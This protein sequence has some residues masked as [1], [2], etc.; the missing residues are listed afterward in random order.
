MPSISR[1]YPAAVFCPSHRAGADDTLLVQVPAVAAALCLPFFVNFSSQEVGRAAGRSGHLSHQLS[2][3]TPELTCSLLHVSVCLCLVSSPSSLIV[4]TSHSRKT[5]TT[6]DSSSVT[7]FISSTC[8]EPHRRHLYTL[9][10]PLPLVPY[11]YQ[12]IFH[13]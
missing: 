6:I 3:H 8:T 13:Y 4:K 10:S 12:F 9:V 1:S 11:E 2:P 7:C 5:V